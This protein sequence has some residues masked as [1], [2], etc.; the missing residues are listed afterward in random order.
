VR[1]K[2][3]LW[4]SRYKSAKTI[5][6]GL[7]VVGAALLVASYFASSSVLS[8]SGLGLI[9]WGIILLYIS[10]ARTVSEKVH[11]SISLSL[12]G[13]IDRLVVHMNYKGRTIFLH[14]KFMSALRQGYIFIPYEESTI[15]R[16]PT[17]EQLAEERTLYEDPKGIFLEAPSQGLVELFERELNV[18]FATID[19]VFIKE[20]L[21]KLL[22][23]NL[24]ITD[25]IT[26][27]EHSEFIQVG[28]TGRSAAKTCQAVSKETQ[29]GA[30][31]GCPLCAS[32]ALLISKVTGKPVSIE[33]SSVNDRHNTINTVYKILEIPK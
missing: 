21:P 24:R 17:D 14:P 27:D 32:I 25:D 29:I 26:I 16:L 5:G 10:P 28:I 2:Q 11:G 13:S 12:I 31:F 7:I 6:I 19:M 23:N 9:I 15:P 8:L 20:N 3:Q 33:S 1:L 4:K 22:T 18:N 30:H